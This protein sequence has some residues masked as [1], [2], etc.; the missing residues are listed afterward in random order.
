M[1]GLQ[2]ISS[3]LVTLFYLG[4]SNIEI[5]YKTNISAL[6]LNLMVVSYFLSLGT[7]LYL[8][9]VTRKR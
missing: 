3:I 6:N 4:L 1:N 7:T 5:H 2:S 8:A 9:F